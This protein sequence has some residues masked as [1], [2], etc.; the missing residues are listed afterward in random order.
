[1]KSCGL[2][3]IKIGTHDV[4][5]QKVTEALQ[6]THGITNMNDA[7]VEGY[8]RM[9]TAVPLRSWENWF[10]RIHNVTKVDEITNDDLVGYEGGTRVTRLRKL[11]NMEDYIDT[12]KGRRAYRLSPE[13]VNIIN[14]TKK[15]LLAKGQV[16]TEEQIEGLIESVE[17][18]IFVDKAVTNANLLRE[19]AKKNVKRKLGAS[20]AYPILNSLVNVDPRLVKQEH[21]EMYNEVL[22]ALSQHGTVLKLRDQSAL[23]EKAKIILEG[24]NEQ[25]I[26]DVPAEDLAGKKIRIEK[27]VTTRIDLNSLSLTEDEMKVVKELKKHLNKESL[28]LLD[29]NQLQH[30]LDSIDNIIGGF[31]PHA[32]YNLMIDMKANATVGKIVPEIMK[33]NPKINLTNAGQ[34]LYGKLKNAALRNNSNEIAEII[35]SSPFTVVDEVFGSKGKEIYNNVFRVLGVARSRYSQESTAITAQ[36]DAL[37]TKWQKAYKGNDLTRSK[38]K[39][40]LLEKAKEAQANPGQFSALSYANAIK[41]AVA[42]GKTTFYRNEDVKI[43]DELINKYVV[44]GE[45]NIAKLEASL[46]PIEKEAIKHNQELSREMAPKVV[47]TSGVIRG[48]RVDTLLEY[49][50]SN[51]IDA[52]GQEADLK[53][54]QARYKGSAKAGTVEERAKLDNAPL[55]TLDPVNDAVKAAKMTLLD[56]HMT[57]AIRETTRITSRTLEQVATDNPGSFAITAAQGLDIAVNEII[58][59]DIANQAEQYSFSTETFKTIVKN[60]Y[61]V[62]LAS[63]PRAISELTSNISMAIVS[64]PTET[65]KGVSSPMAKDEAVALYI[66]NRGGSVQMGK[67]YDAGTWAGKYVE[68]SFFENKKKRNTRAL[69]SA[70]EKMDRVTGALLR[71]PISQKAGQGMDY[72]VDKLLSGPDKL[73]GRAVFWGSFEVAFEEQTGKKF[74]SSKF[75]DEAYWDRYADE[76]EFALKEADKKS[77]TVSATDNIYSGSAK[78]KTKA[79]ETTRNAWRVLSGYLMTFLIY[80]ASTFRSGVLSL[81]GKGHYTKAQGARILLGATLRMS[82]YFPMMTMLSYGMAKLLGF[83][84]EEPEP[85]DEQLKLEVVGSLVTIFTQGRLSG[86]PRIPISMLIEDINEDHLG[87]LRGNE[88]YDPYKHSLVFNLVSEKDFRYGKSLPDLLA[89]LSGPFRPLIRD[90]GSL[91]K[92]YATIITAKDEGKISEAE[93]AMLFKILMMSLGYSGNLPI[94]RDIMKVYRDW[95]WKIKQDAKK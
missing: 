83:D 24:L 62:Q 73:V 36:A 49:S 88:E 61:A 74:D 42:G 1:M 20:D 85:I 45:F 25:K 37:E 46:S 59:T 87:F 86:F 52:K 60:S 33:I 95:M 75:D 80:E 21:R 16:L 64:F 69:T 4:P 40:K 56:Y 44:D 19:K 81:V 82:L 54:L 51:V 41:K 68:T 76:I 22:A 72:M 15:N 50:H 7:I 79:G 31:V 58:E 84:P 39:V 35:R 18:A 34:R 9:P 6:A 3:T 32:A 53:N 43:L 90:L 48:E 77:I 38:Y 66:M 67:F 70:E 93:A 10:R 89:K 94:Y 26:Y 30:L 13:T 11:L 2:K 78:L 28:E 8:K 14:A 17:S 63:L 5:F 27:L 29:N 23:L 92:D 71:N 55:I 57:P 12:V 65:I 91:H 47:F